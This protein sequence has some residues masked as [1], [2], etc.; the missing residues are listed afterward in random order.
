MG[1]V[2][3]VITPAAEHFLPAAE[4][5]WPSEVPILRDADEWAAWKQLGDPV[6]HIDL[7][8]WGDLLL[9]APL[10]ADAMAKLAGGWADNLLLS[11]ARAW[12]FAKPVVVA[13]A[14]NTFMWEHPATA[15]H[16]RILREWG[17]TVVEPVSKALACGDVGIG[18][19]ADADAIIAAVRK[20]LEQAA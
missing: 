6:L 7:R 16:L 12:D 9:L 18:A 14:M 3:A 8:R 5:P 17:A 2:R 15:E 10:S 19:L 20:A 4:E 13:P 11:V 1:E